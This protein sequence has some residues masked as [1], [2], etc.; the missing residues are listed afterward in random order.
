MA[1]TLVFSYKRFSSKS[2][3]RGTSIAR[4]TKMARDWVAAQKGMVL[5]DLTFT[6][7][8]IS[9][10][11]GSNIRKGALGQFLELIRTGEIAR[12]SILVI[13]QWDRLTRQNPLDAIPLVGDILKA[14]VEI[15]TLYPEQR[16]T[17]KATRDASGMQ[18]MQMVFILLGSYCK[19][20]SNSA[21]QGGRKVRQLVDLRI[22]Q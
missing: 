1:Q 19:R 9:G 18:L 11:D 16:Y 15:Q 22:H 2:Q 20:R 10:F 17:E 7:S 14:G 8:G 21:A 3:G 5:S 4:Q 13:E 6:D 12:G